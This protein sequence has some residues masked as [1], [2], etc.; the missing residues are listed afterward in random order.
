MV[1]SVMAGNIVQPGVRL[2]LGI[3]LIL[4][5][6]DQAGMVWALN[7][8]VV[9]GIG[10]AVWY[11][12]R[13]MTPAQ[14]TAPVRFG[15]GP[16][17]KFSLPQ[18]GASL[19]GV[20]SLGL[21]I[22]ILGIFE[23]DRAVGL[24]GIALSLQGPGN[25]F[26]GGIVNIWAPVVSDLYDRG[27]IDRLGSLYQTINRWIATFSFPVFAALMIEPDVFVR[28]FAGPRAAS[29]A[30]VVAILALG[31]LFYTGTGPTGYVISMTGYPIVNFIN[32]VVS[33]GLY[34]GLGWW[35]VPEHGLV[36]MAWT[37]AIVT[38]LVNSVRVV[39]AKLLVGVQPFGRT[40]YKPCLAT[41]VGAA[42]LLLW[43][44]VVGDSIPLDLTGVALGAV[45]YVYTLKRLG[46]DEEERHV[47]ERIRARAFKRG[48]KD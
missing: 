42:V 12:D 36:G 44:Q 21:G 9:A 33:V 19:L 6:L 41:M 14:R 40:F 22:L 32:S 16:M 23:T 28:L 13:L 1:P 20:Q 4:V 18:A 43:N 38:A 31:N 7:I 15:F 39:E 35:L 30:P 24:F 25:V 26:L 2:V 34:I 17:L 3:G 48:K 27:A 37:D 46:M 29:A 47:I 10:V 11:L 45:A 8:G 5:G